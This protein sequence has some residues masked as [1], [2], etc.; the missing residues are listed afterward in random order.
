MWVGLGSLCPTW[1]N[2]LMHDPILINGWMDG[3]ME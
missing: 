2:F 1:G 3:W